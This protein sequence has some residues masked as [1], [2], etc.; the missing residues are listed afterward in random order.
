MRNNSFLFQTSAS[1]ALTLLVACNTHLNDK[2][3]QT[4]T[5]DT[6]SIESKVSTP[7]SVIQFLI[8]S[9]AA[10]FNEHKPPTAIDIRNVKTGFIVSGNEKLYLICGEF[11]SKEKNEWESFT[12]I[13]TSGYEQYIGGDSYCQKATFT[14]TDSDILSEGI[15]SKLTVLKK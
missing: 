4:N 7:D 1:I 3:L 9:A 5:S 15:K 11:L 8:A 14:D 6:T 12:T 2:T 13:K 10:D